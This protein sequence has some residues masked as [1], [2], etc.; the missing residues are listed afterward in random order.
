[1][2][3]SV[4][5]GSSHTRESPHS[6]SKARG[7]ACTPNSLT[8]YRH[9]NIG[10]EPAT[11]SGLVQVGVGVGGEGKEVCFLEAGRSQR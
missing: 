11:G 1:M 9:K 10:P 3:A 2:M 8:H 6:G 4:L 7:Y 5:G